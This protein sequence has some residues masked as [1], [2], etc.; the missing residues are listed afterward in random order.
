MTPQQ[1]GVSSMPRDISYRGDHLCHLEGDD[2]Y[3]KE[4]DKVMTPDQID[5][6]F[7]ELAG[8]CWHVPTWD[9][10]GFA[11][12]YTKKKL[13]KCSVCGKLISD[14]ELP[15]CAYRF[16]AD[17]RL[18]L[19]EMKRV[20]KT[21]FAFSDFL[22]SLDVSGTYAILLTGFIDTYILDTTGKLAEAAITFLEKK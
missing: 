22:F 14:K 5:K 9:R 1:F 12:R 8:I 3:R 16:C 18:V 15:E 19:V 2:G 6:R 17:P 13:L 20:C 10:N 11:R 21:P 7:A 4:K